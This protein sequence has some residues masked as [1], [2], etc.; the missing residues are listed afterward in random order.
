MTNN[1]ASAIDDFPK[2]KNGDWD[3]RND[4]TRNPRL[5]REAAF[6]RLNKAL[7]SQEGDLAYEK[8]LSDAENAFMAGDYD[9]MCKCLESIGH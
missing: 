6:E 9:G 2:D 4:K 1:T 7:K 8:A 3:W 5:V